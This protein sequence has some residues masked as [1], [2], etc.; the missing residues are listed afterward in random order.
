MANRPWYRAESPCWTAH[1]R[2][3][4]SHAAAY[5]SGE[6]RPL[7]EAPQASTVPS[8]K[9][10]S[11]RRSRPGTHHP[12]GRPATESG[13]NRRAGDRSA[14]QSPRGADPLRLGLSRWPS[15]GAVFSGPPPQIRSAGCR[16]GIR[17]VRGRL[18]FLLRVRHA[19]SR[20][21]AGSPR[22][23]LNHLVDQPADE[24]D[25]ADEEE[26]GQEDELGIAEI[27]Q[28]VREKNLSPDEA[29]ACNKIADDQ[30]LSWMKNAPNE[31]GRT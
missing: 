29:P 12:A 18:Q 11:R 16:R 20:L 13:I 4:V 15:P 27:A 22:F 10:G 25:T 17:D 7:V 5:R 1:I 3:T 24:P 21:P 2:S 23:A 26:H 14:L 8:S 30:G 6:A 28:V 9:S 19:D 31:S